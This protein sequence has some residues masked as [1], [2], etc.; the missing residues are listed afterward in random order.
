LTADGEKTKV[1]ITLEDPPP[2][3]SRRT[4]SATRR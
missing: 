1:V 2:L 4:T 3:S